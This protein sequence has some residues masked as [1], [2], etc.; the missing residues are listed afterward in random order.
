MQAYLVIEDKDEEE[1]KRVTLDDRG[2]SKNYQKFGAGQFDR[3]NGGDS[4]V[5]SVYYDLDEFSEL[6]G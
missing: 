5:V 4:V 1:V 3:K 2:K 6:E